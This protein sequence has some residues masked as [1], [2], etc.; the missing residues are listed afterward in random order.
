MHA[1]SDYLRKQ[2]IR[3]RRLAGEIGAADVQ[4]TLEAM[5]TEYEAR[6]AFLEAAQLTAERFEDD[7]P[8]SA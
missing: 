7:D 8:A 3:C 5:A 6:A 2:A 4:K 1:D